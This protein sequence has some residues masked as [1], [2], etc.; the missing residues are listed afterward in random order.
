MTYKCGAKTAKGSLCKRNVK[1]KDLKCWQHLVTEEKRIISQDDAKS[2]IEKRFKYSDRTA[3]IRNDTEFKMKEKLKCYDENGSE[4]QFIE[5]QEE[6]CSGCELR[7]KW[8]FMES[9]QYSRYEV[10]SLGRFH[11]VRTDR[12]FNGKIDDDNY[13]YCKISLVHDNSKNRTKS[14]ATWMGLIC[15]NISIGDKKFSA[16][17]I[18]RKRADNR[19]CNL[20]KATRKQQAKNRNYKPH[21]NG[22]LVEKLSLEGII[23]ETFI[24]VTLAAKNIGISQPYMSSL[25]ERKEEYEGARWRYFEHVDSEKEVWLWSTDAFPNFEPFEASSEGNV[26]INGRVK[27]GNKAGRYLQVYLKHKKSSKFKSK[28]VHVL[29]CTIFHGSCPKWANQIS[30]KDTNG[31]NNKASNLEWNNGS[32]NMINS[33]GRKVRAIF[34]NE[35][36]VDFNSIIEAAKKFKTHGSHIVAVC[37]GKRK[38][39]GK[40]EYGNKIREEYICD[41]TEIM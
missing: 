14:T 15:L 28:L 40:D 36:Y 2:Q 10:S 23:L 39:S 7:E 35:T 20:R 8:Y 27:K 9:I 3:I 29:I 13:G 18:N 24:S 37:K 16:D 30:H 5:G 26:R 34:T 25:C 12:F 1:E 22:R 6:I 32:G 19:L 31:K 4:G 41:E 38:T 33:V 17:H 21:H 11:N